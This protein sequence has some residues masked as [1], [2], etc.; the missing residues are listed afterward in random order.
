[1]ADHTYSLTSRPAASTGLVTDDST[2][3][4]SNLDD[5]TSFNTNNLFGNFEKE[6][7]HE[8]ILY[9]DC[10]D[11]IKDPDYVPPFQTLDVSCTGQDSYEVRNETNHEVIEIGA[12]GDNVQFCP[13]GEQPQ[14]YSLVLGVHQ[15]QHIIRDN[16]GFF[17][18][19]VKKQKK[20]CTYNVKKSQVNAQQLDQF[21]LIQ[22]INIFNCGGYI[23]MK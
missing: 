23:T 12:T 8:N 6:N 19:K 21:L 2:S 13:V 10:D 4:I 5:S 20:K 1:M 7:E 9:S 14:S 17:T 11:S 18:L 16:L 22:I 3:S 15:H